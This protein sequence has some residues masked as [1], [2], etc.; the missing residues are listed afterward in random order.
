ML[1]ECLLPVQ[2]LLLIKACVAWGER[3]WKKQ[4]QDRTSLDFVRPDSR[5][6]EERGSTTA[7]AREKLSV[8]LHY[9]SRTVN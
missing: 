2:E 5:L 9:V 1:I 3:D 8:T 7:V 6:V 4:A